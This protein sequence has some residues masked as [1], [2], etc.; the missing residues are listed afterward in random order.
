MS[1]YAPPL[2]TRSRKETRH[3]NKYNKWD[4]EAVTESNEP[5]SFIAGIDVKY[6]SKNLGIVSYYANG[7]PIKSCKSYYNILCPVLLNL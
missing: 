6:P 7:I 3:I 1:Y 4:V 2:L 5:C